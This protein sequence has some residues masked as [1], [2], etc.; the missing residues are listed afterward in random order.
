[1]PESLGGQIEHEIYAD[2]EDIIER[3]EAISIK[4]RSERIL[5]LIIK[6]VKGIENPYDIKHGMAYS[7]DKE[8]IW[9]E[10]IQAVIKELEEE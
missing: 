6:R 9:D 10:A 1:M 7:P 3:N 4:R 2:R 5:P 8:D